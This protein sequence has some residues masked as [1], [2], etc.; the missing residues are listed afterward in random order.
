MTDFYSHRHPDIM[1]ADH[2]RIVGENSRDILFET[3]IFALDKQ[4]LLDVAYLIGI[5]HDFGKFTHFFQDYLNKKR[6]GDDLTHHG[7]ISA[8]FTYEVLLNFIKIQKQENHPIFKYIPLIGYFVVKHHHGNLNNIKNDLNPV[9]IHTEFS[10]IRQQITDIKTNNQKIKNIYIPLFS[11]TGIQVSDIFI[12]LF[13]Y[14]LE[15]SSPDELDQIIKSLRKDHRHFD[16]ETFDKKEI[17]VFLITQLLY[18]IL[19]DSDKKHAGHV[20]SIQRHSIPHDI[21]EQY[22]AR[23]EFRN[24][25]I[26]NINKIR[27]D[28]FESVIQNIKS[29]PDKKI[30]SITAPTGT[31]KTLTSLAAALKIRNNSPSQA[32]IIYALPFTSIIDQNCDVFENVLKETIPDF[33]NNES[34]Y[35]LKHHHLA[36]FTYKYEGDNKPVEESLALTE[37]WDSEIIVTTFIQ[38]FYS[39]I[40]YKNK[41]LKKF[42][43]I[44]GS[45]IILDEVQNIPIKYWKLVGAVLSALTRFF[46]CTIILLTATQPLIFQE[47]ECTELVENYKQ[48]FSN[49]ELNRVILNFD[50]TERTIEETISELNISPEKSYLFVLNTIRSS[51][52]FYNELAKKLEYEGATNICIEYLSTNIVPKERRERISRIKEEL[53][54]GEKKVIVSTQ[55]IE[56]GIDIDVDVVY[57]DLGPLDSIIQVAGRCNRKKR[58]KQGDVHIINLI[59]QKGRKYSKIYDNILLKIVLEILNEHPVVDETQFLELIDLY[60]TKS[61][62]D[63]Y[64]DEKIIRALFELN[65]YKNPKEVDENKNRIPISEFKL[66]EEDQPE[67]DIFVELDEPAHEIWIKYIHIQEKTG[68]E[69]KILFLGIKK[70]FYDYVISVP[71]NKFPSSITGDSGIGRITRAELKNYYDNKTG[72]SP[73]DGGTLIL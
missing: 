57:R 58:V 33:E 40:G 34:P 36:E 11:G 1:L 56:A 46:D 67:C 49:T 59:N 45:I 30:F 31:G 48:Y 17:V 19:I 47:N 69:R 54:N 71:P 55:L 50:K 14:G 35:L 12:N 5:S 44:A 41:F 64:I 27:N 7:L 10:N 70:Q 24:A 32:R 60:F 37:S 2:L 23:P 16:N 38:F 9:H 25:N 13:R 53:E 3:R 63:M 62:K 61:Q 68:L 29:N 52:E 18:S 43:N 4:F 66:I 6:P 28:I 21:V 39:T 42:H 65:Y 15:Y 72:F 22:I 51:I 26:S 73:I 20:E 8:L